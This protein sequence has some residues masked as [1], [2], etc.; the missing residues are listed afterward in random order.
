VSD[1][2]GVPSSDAVTLMRYTPASVN[3]GVNSSDPVPSPLSTNAPNDRSV[4]FVLNDNVSDTSGSVAD[5]VKLSVAPSLTFCAPIAA[6]VGAPLASVT[7]SVNVSVSD[8]TGVPS[9]DAVTL[10]RN[11][12]ASVNPGVNSSDPVPSP[13]ST[14][15]P[16]DRSVAFVLNDNVSDTSG[17][18]ADIVKLSTMPSLMFFAPIAAR[19]G[20]VLVIPPK[21]PVVVVPPVAG[22]DAEVESRIP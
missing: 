8:R 18:V 15:A 7:V 16:N 3:P 21:S 2:T 20:V 11:T 10:M 12:P 17:S 6:R 14:N 4:A 1:R 9:S 5:I 22:R 13:L 19:V